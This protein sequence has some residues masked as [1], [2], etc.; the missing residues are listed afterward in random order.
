MSSQQTCTQNTPNAGGAGKKRRRE[1]DME[2]RQEEDNR[3][4]E[5]QDLSDEEDSDGE[6]THGEVLD[7]KRKQT[8]K[9]KVLTRIRHRNEGIGKLAGNH[10]VPKAATP[11]ARAIHEFVRMLMGIP[12]KSRG[13]S[14]LEDAGEKKMP[15]PPSELEHQ[16]WESR[17]QRREI[18]IREAQ[19]HAMT[20]YLSKKPPGFKPNQKQRRVVEKDAAEMASLKRPMQPVI[21]TSRIL[22]GIRTR[23]AHHW[24]TSCEA[25][26]A[27]AGF[28]RCTF[29]WES[30]YDSPWNS[31]TATIILAHWVKAYEAN[32]AR[33]F[34]ILVTDNTPA[35]R[36][37][38]LRRWCGNKA[39]KFQDQTRKV[40]LTKT[41]EGRKIL[42]DNISIA[43]GISSK[44][45]NMNK[46]YDARLYMAVKLFGADS[47]EF[48]MLS[49]PEVHSEDELVTT[50]CGSRQKLRLEWR[51][52]ELDTLIGLLDTA[53]WK[54]KTIPKERRLAKQLV[55]RGT[56]SP[57]PNK[58]RFPPKGFQ[59][60]LVSPSW[61]DQQ[62]GL[63]LS[64]L[65][66][67]EN[68][69][70]D[71]HSAVE[72]AKI[73]FKSLSALAAEQQNEPSGS[74]TMNTQ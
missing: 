52:Q 13:S 45:Q 43:K 61:Y 24:V 54:R 26:L 31:V 20:K 25:S 50:N 9:L 53:Y 38:V 47:P 35:N 21:F 57:T 27:M 48:K 3:F 65:E 49:H 63:V 17:R 51:S 29:D 10:P 66:L 8:A 72:D 36:E 69:P 15:D 28:P 70:V 44:K 37:E 68:H 64:E 33:E 11:L 22:T 56:Y 5:V 18:F 39:P 6:L 4:D 23:Y 30:S 60:L 71:I 74:H 16:A 42:E 55:E 40:A 59:Q 2:E 34:G 32:G 46:I 41:P 1:G 14:A 67:N 73:T 7:Q 19:D 12:R 62:E 58:D